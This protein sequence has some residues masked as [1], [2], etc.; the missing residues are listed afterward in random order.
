MHNNGIAI[1]IGIGIAIKKVSG[2]SRS[3]FPVNNAQLETRNAKR[4]TL[5][6]LVAWIL[7][8][9]AIMDA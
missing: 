9:H 8:G 3:L 5:Y 6:A 4:E 7:V 1:G 2:F